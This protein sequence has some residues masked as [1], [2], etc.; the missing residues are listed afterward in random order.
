MN[1]PSARV[2]VIALASAWSAATVT[3]SGQYALDDGEPDISLGFNLPA[4]FGW[5]QRF[6]AVGGT[7]LITDIQVLIPGITDGRPVHLCVWED[8]DDDGDP[9][10]AQ[11]VATVTG[12]VRSTPGFARYAL[13]SPGLVHGRFFVGAYLTVEGW[14]GPAAIDKDAVVPNIAWA[15][16][17]YVQGGF[18]PYVLGNNFPPFHIETVGAMFHGAFLIRATGAGDV[19]TVYC[20]AKTNSLGCVP[21]ISYSGIASASA[22]SGFVV[23]GSN[24]FNGKAGMLIYGTNGRA[25]IPFAGGTLCVAQPLQRT[26]AQ[27]S[28]GTPFGDDCTGYYAFDFNAWIALGI[29]R[30][31]VPGTV[32]DAQYWSRDAGFALP[33]NVGLTDAIEF[34]IAP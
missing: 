30:A 15:T 33:D 12:S 7:D 4:D 3:A 18:D 22:G 5:L 28:G 1:A 9:I 32:V 26:P 31:L 27:N 24:L 21:H 29:D 19:P 10:D 2:L 23:S 11:L 6:D 16:W 14:E 20:N 25:S 17:N 34:T 13:P 8:P